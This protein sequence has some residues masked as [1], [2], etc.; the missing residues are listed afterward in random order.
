MKDINS[1][2]S[3]NIRKILKEYNLNQNELAKIAEVSESTVGKWVLKKSVPRAGAIEKISNH[4]G[5]P[6]SYLLK[7]SVPSNLMEISQET[8]KIPVLGEIACG[9]PLLV[10]ENIVDYR[11]AVKDNTPAGTTFYLQAKGDSMYPTI[12]DGSMVLV[13]HQNDA[14]NGEIVAAM[15]DDH[16]EA[17]LKRIRKQ[18]D[19]IMLLPDNN[20]H[21]PIIS[22]KDNPV[23]IIGKAIKVERDL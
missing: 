13:R 5:L 23:R 7:E 20:E 4:F 9:S 1:I 21:E 19:T 22:T 2:V 15:F 17:T 18:G 3:A 10:K 16:N 12:P 8:I 14:E 11:V 6:K